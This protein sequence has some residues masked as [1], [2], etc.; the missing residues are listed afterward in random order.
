[1]NLEKRRDEKSQGLIPGVVEGVYGITPSFCGM[2][3]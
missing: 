3:L 2:R 1:M